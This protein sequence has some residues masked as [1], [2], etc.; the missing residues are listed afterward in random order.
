MTSDATILSGAITFQEIV[1]GTSRKGVEYTFRKDLI[2]VDV[3]DRINITEIGAAMMR[4]FDLPFFRKDIL[5]EIKYT[6]QVPSIDQFWANWLHEIGNA[7]RVVEM[8][9]REVLGLDVKEEGGI[10]PM[11]TP[12][13]EAV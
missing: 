6:K 9:F 2:S 1:S 5:R 8:T 4:G 12:A 13:A 11:Q 3:N 7:V 10:L